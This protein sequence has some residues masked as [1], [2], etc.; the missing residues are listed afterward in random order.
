MFEIILFYRIFILQYITSYYHR[1]NVDFWQVVCQ[2][3]YLSNDIFLEN[4]TL[5]KINVSDRFD[6]RSKEIIENIIIF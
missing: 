2:M 5:S 6:A 1:L 4:K 3:I